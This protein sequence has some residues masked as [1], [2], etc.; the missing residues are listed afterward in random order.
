MQF[1]CN[2]GH[3]ST[4]PDCELP[5]WWYFLWKTSGLFVSA[6]VINFSNTLSNYLYQARLDLAKTAK[7]NVLKL[8]ASNVYD[9]GKTFQKASSEVRRWTEKEVAQGVKTGLTEEKQ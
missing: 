7:N 6:Y 2:E 4:K 8:A 5:I 9:E 3:S 1:Y